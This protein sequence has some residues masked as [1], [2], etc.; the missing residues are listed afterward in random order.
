MLQGDDCERLREF[1]LYAQ[2][3]THGRRWTIWPEYSD[4]RGGAICTLKVA[5]GVFRVMSLYGFRLCWWSVLLLLRF[6]EQA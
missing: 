6:P 4:F 1:L 3:R 2:A 5:I